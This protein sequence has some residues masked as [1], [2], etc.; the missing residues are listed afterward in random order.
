MEHG[1][2][3]KEQDGTDLSF[4]SDRK[5]ALLIRNHNSGTE[6]KCLFEG[7]AADRREKDNLCSQYPEGRLEDD[8]LGS[9]EESMIVQKILKADVSAW[10]RDLMKGEKALLDCAFVMKEGICYPVESCLEPDEA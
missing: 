10:K 7:T 1:W 5:W 6:G 4:S 2:I 3:R 8:V 9:I